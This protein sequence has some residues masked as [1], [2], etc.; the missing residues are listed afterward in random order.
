MNS[1]ETNV[2]RGLLLTVLIGLLMACGG[3]GGGGG[4]ASTSEPV[5]AKGVIT[6][7]GSI[8][9]NGVEYETPEGGSYSSDD[10]SDFDPKLYQPGQVVRIRGKLHDDGVS[11]TA[12]EVEYEAEIEGTAG[13]GNTINGYNIITDQ[14]LTPGTR[15]EVSGFWIDDS[16]IDATFIKVDDDNDGGIDEIKGFIDVL[17]PG[18]S[19]NVRGVTYIFTNTTAFSEGDFVEVHFNPA[20]CTGSIPNRTCDADIVESEDDFNDEIEGLEVEFEGAVNMDPTDLAKCPIDADFMI[21]P[22]CIDWDL[23]PSDG[24][25]DGLTGSAD[26]M[27]G[28]RVEA[29]GH[30]NL[31]GLL[32]AEKIKG[33]GN[34]VR[35][36]A[37]VSNVDGTGGLGTLEVF[38]GAIQV[39]TQ[40]GLT[41]IENPL[42]NGDGFEIRGIRTGATSVLALRIKSDS[43]GSNDHE[44]RAEVDLN[45]ANSGAGTITVMGITSLANSDTELQDEDFVVAPGNGNTTSLQIINFLGSIDDDGIVSTTNG[46]N[47]VV[48][49][50]IDTTDNTARQIEIER[51]DD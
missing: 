26:M 15:Y 32:I 19:I 47:D 43:V 21:G 23:V 13:T 45:G 8:W 22:T 5:V 33:R 4:T 1:F 24:W 35:I 11:G 46:P 51:E 16:T 37:T 36:S 29:E 3:G 39:T 28:L 31:A 6:Q 40:S 38:G 10:D 14:S 18:T 49:V 48:D 30:F 20:S 27:P 50:R 7:L 12:D 17:V 44:L 34:R 42:V 9:V 41:S 25:M 2:I